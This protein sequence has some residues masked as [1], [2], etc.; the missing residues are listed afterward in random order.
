MGEYK[1][2]ILWMGCILVVVIG[3]LIYDHGLFS[4]KGDA[5]T[6]DLY[7]SE[8]QIQ[9]SNQSESNSNSNS[10]QMKDSVLSIDTITHSNI[11][12]EVTI[13]G[14]VRTIKEHENGHLFLNVTDD[15]GEISVP[16]FS[17]KGIDKDYIKEGMTYLFTG[18]VKEFNN[19]LEISIESKEN[20]RMVNTTNKVTEENVG[21]EVTIYGTILSKYAHPD[22]HVFMTILSDSEEIEVP[23][24]KNNQIDIDDIPI[25]SEVGIK[26]TIDLYKDQLEVIPQKQEDIEIIELG[27]EEEID[28]I[29]VSDISSELRGKMVQVRGN[30]KDAAEHDGHV[31][32]TLVDGSDE[33]KSVLFKAD[34]NEIEGR[35]IKIMQAQEEDFPIRILAMVDF[36]DNEL[37]VIVDKVFIQY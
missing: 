24:F 4:T 26:G 9:S 35:K 1:K 18:K 3:Y 17:D 27:N 29:K 7:T 2:L 20:M 19:T 15:T 13:E 22:G 33:I 30:V 34:G 37:E 28:L 8:G 6:T 14:T 31:F 11:G 21:K 23:I 10:N 16:I 25:N 12:E 36:Y 32:F 5:D